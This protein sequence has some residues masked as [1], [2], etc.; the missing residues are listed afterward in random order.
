MTWTSPKYTRHQV[1]PSRFD[2][3]SS[4]K[5]KKYAEA[6][7]KFGALGGIVGVVVSG[8]RGVMSQR[9]EEA[10]MANMSFKNTIL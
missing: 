7:I 6:F 2:I 5:L 9:K 10:Y 4:S 1:C 8:K 3:I